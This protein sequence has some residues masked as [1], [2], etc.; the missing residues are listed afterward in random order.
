MKRTL[1]QFARRWISSPKLYGW[2]RTGMLFVQYVTRRPDEPDLRFLPLGLRGSGGQV[3]DI[4]ANGGQSA[5][6][7]RY[8]FPT[9]DIISF[10]PLPMLWPEL[11]RIRV[12]LGSTF[13]WRGC[14]LGEGPGTFTLYVPVFDELPITTRASMDRDVAEQHCTELERELGTRSRVETIDV[15]VR[16]GDQENLEPVAI[17]IDVEGAEAEVLR[18]LAR[19]VERCRPNILLERSGSFNECA[20]WVIGRDYSVLTCDGA[21]GRA[22]AGLSPENWMAV[23]NERIDAYFVDAGG[24]AV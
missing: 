11:R 13:S 2:L 16:P 18:G 3:L 10:E 4:G 22:L 12:F 19:T 8:L 1:V 9:S 5:V 6:A 24:N 17:K 14:A 20:D 7:L 21:R 23:P 15:E